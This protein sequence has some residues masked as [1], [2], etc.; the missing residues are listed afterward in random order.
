[1]PI[2]DEPRT[3]MTGPHYTC[4]L[5]V[6]DGGWIARK[7]PKALLSFDR[8]SPRRILHGHGVNV[9]LADRQFP[10][11]RQKVLD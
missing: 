3:Q 8:K 7:T 5:L 9:I 6:A 4:F 10:Q 1:M 2:G 11:A